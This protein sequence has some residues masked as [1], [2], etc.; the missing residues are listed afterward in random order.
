MPNLS[1]F[2]EWDDALIQE[3]YDKVLWQE[4][5]ERPEAADFPDKVPANMRM[6][7]RMVDVLIQH[8]MKEGS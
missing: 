5:Q 7:L 1:S 2:R 4:W 3:V 6:V 8:R